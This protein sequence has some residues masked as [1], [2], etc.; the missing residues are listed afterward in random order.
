MKARVLFLAVAAMSLTVAC[1]TKP[2]EE[3]IDSTPA[4]D[5]M[6]E[7]VVDLE[8]TPDSIPAEEVAAPAP[9]KKKTTTT[10]KKETVDPNALKTN[11]TQTTLD[12]GSTVNTGKR[13]R[14]GDK[15]QTGSEKEKSTGLTTGKRQRHSQN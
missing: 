6:I 8:E 14:Q 5:T 4:E 11:E 3:P 15:L 10:V 7:Q 1:N 13:E 2:A 9:V 12:N